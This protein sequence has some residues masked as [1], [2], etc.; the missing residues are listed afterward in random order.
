LHSTFKISVLLNMVTKK[1][2]KHLK[3]TLENDYYETVLKL[4]S[5]VDAAAAEKVTGKIKDQGKK[6]VRQFVKKI[7]TASDKKAVKAVVK[8][9]VAKKTASRKKTAV[10]K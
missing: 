1:S 9:K 6:L 7:K 8:K 4:F 5:G 3:K 2:P 10:K